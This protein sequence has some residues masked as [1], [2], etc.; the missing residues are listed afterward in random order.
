MRI[1]HVIRRVQFEVRQP[2]RPSGLA[3]IRLPA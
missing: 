3:S 2:P 1:I